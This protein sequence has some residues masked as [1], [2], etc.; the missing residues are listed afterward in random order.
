MVSSYRFGLPG[1]LSWIFEDR[2]A[3][4]VEGVHA[5][6]GVAVAPRW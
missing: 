2:G 3:A 1:P 4:A 6:I 5:N